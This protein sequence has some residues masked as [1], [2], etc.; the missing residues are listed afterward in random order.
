MIINMNEQEKDWKLKLRY[1]QLQTPY[2]H[3][4]LIARRIVG[5]L[6]DGFSCIPGNAFMGMKVWAADYDEAV[7]MIQNI[8]NQIGF[9][10]SGNIEIFDS[11]PKQPPKEDPF[12]YEINFTLYQE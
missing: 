5:Q 12:G 7:A 11:E 3:F 1:G 4:T 8:G 9:T 6:A 10:V 2:Q